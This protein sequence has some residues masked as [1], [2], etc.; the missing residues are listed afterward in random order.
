MKFGQSIKY[1]ERN[2]N[3]NHVENEPE[4][5]VSD[6]FLFFKKSLYEVKAR[7]IQLS[8]NILWLPSTCHTIKTNNIKL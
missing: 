8:F 6:L 1:N 3:K 5:L 4:G 2:I 7:G